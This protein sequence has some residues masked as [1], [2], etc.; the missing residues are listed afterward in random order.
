MAKGLDKHRQR[1]EALSQFGKDLTRRCGSSCELCGA[2]GTKLQIHEVPPAPTAPDYD[3]C[4]MLCEICKE[5]IEHPKRMD[6]NHWRCL[7]GAV[8]SEV[9]AVQVMA[10][11]L[12]KLLDGHDWANELMEQL[13][14]S[15]E[16]EQWLEKLS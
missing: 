13:Y 11:S 2:S 1:I 8:W 10:V 16:S 15:P 3:H 12:L 4:I 5:Q 6:S 14:L 7:N 9:T